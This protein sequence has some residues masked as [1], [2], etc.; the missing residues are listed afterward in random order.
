MIG[1]LRRERSFRAY[2][3]LRLHV[4][5]I[6]TQVIDLLT[7]RAEDAAGGTMGMLRVAFAG[8]FSA[9]LEPTVRARLGMPCDV[10]LADETGIVSRH[11]R[12]DHPRVHP[13]DGRGREA[14]EARPGARRRPRSDRSRRAAGGGAPGERLWPRDRHRRVRAGRDAHADARLRAARRG[15]PAGGLGESVGGGL[16][17]AGALAGAGGKDARHP[18]L[19][20]DRAGSGPAGARVR[21]GGLR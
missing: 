10:I 18:R 2:T 3:T 21:H 9:T 12:A 4:I 5:S 7:T 15:A 11:G 20:S 17:A 19:R 1:W 14:T 6:T 8:T 13:R 16:V